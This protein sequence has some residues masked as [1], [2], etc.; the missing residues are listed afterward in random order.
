MG[1]GNRVGSF[2][3]V[4]CDANMLPLVIEKFAERLLSA[5][6]FRGVKAGMRVRVCGQSD[7]GWNRCVSRFVE[8]R[9]RPW[10]VRIQVE[11]CP[12]ATYR[13]AGNEL[14]IIVGFLPRHV[15][16]LMRLL[17]RYIIGECEQLRRRGF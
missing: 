17:V 6:A 16:H 14:I 4:A 10:S 8:T 15:F 9:P 5:R 2:W 3:I 7:R 1:L 11:G 13:F 12:G